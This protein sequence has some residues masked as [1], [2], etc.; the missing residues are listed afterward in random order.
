[1]YALFKMRRRRPKQLELRPK[2]WGGKR[3]GAG[4]P[5]GRGRRNVAHR[6]RAPF[7]RRS[8][9]HVTLRMAQHVYG[10]RSGRSQR[11]VE[12]MLRIGADRFG[13][14]VV[15]VSVQGNHIHLLVEALDHVSLGQAMKGLGVRLARGMNAMMGQRG[16]VLG[17]RYH[18]RVL[19]TP[20][21]I[22]HAVQYIRHN[23]RKHEAACGRTL[24]ISFVDP[25]SSDGRLAAYIRR[26]ALHLVE[27]ALG[28][29][30]PPSG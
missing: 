21:E 9:L 8:A 10:L 18:A 19:R 15:Q 2:T 17:D 23:H 24:P 11:V 4:R 5:P 29:G 1:M 26:P 16:R 22:R 20:T 25:C 14:Q 7:S 27:K 13:T 28:T 30:Y 3:E 12:N 6:S